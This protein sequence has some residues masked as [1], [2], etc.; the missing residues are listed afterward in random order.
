VRRHP[1]GWD[2]L[3][4]FYAGDT[5]SHDW[6]RLGGAFFVCPGVRSFH[7]NPSG[8]IVGQHADMLGL[9]GDWSR[10]HRPP[11]V[12]GMR[13][14]I[15]FLRHSNEHPDGSL[16]AGTQVSSRAKGTWRSTPS[17]G[18]PKMRTDFA[19]CETAWCASLCQ[20]KQRSENRPVASQ[21]ANPPGRWGVATVSMPSRH[22]QS[23]WAPASI[24]GTAAFGIGL[25]FEP[26]VATSG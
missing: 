17:V 5:K 6:P 26:S 21:D 12:W 2:R 14:Q 24:R 8:L 20:S 9:T 19:S 22:L 23:R 7:R 13:F 10:G 18:A 15:E 4:P 25:H 16:S 1:C 3:A 11:I